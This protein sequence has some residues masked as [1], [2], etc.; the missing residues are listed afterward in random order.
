MTA[1]LE[2]KEVDLF[3]GR[4]QALNGLS[5]TVEEGEIVSLLGNNGAGKTSTLG[6]LSGLHRAKSGQI[7]WQGEDIT[8]AKPWDLVKKGLIHVPEGRR[9]FSTMTVHENLLLGGYQVSDQ[10]AIAE[11]IEESYELMPRLRERKDQQGGTLS[12]G[13]QQMLAIGRALMSRPKLLMLDEPS[14]GL[15]PLVVKDIFSIVKQIHEAGVTVLLIEQNA[16]AA[17]EI[18]DHAY[19]LEVGQVVLEGSGRDLLVDPRVQSAYLGE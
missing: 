5:I 6:M 15:A 12:G 8:Q 18:A 7:L 2:L 11:R 9:I 14:L 1:E 3:Y 17:L 13:E 16:K 19:V 10:K 4:V